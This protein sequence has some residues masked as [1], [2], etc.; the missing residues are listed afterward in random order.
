M[1][2]GTAHIGRRL[3][4]IRLWRGQS[5]KAVANLAGLSE[6]YL[7]KIE[8]GL[9]PVERRTTLE[10]LAAALRVAPSELTGSPLLVEGMN[11]DQS[12][13]VSLRA[14]L[15]EF[16]LDDDGDRAPAPWVQ[17]RAGVDRVNELRPKAEYTAMALMLPDLLRDLY[18]SLDGPHRREALQGLADCYLSSL[19]ACKNLGYSDLAIACALRIRD[20]S[21]QLAGPE[22]TGLAAYARAQA[23]G[24]GAR[25]RV[26]ALAVKAA[27]DITGDLDQ[28]QVAEVYGMLHLVAALAATTT[29]RLD[30]ARDHVAEAAEVAARPGVGSHGS[31]AGFMHM[32]FGPGNVG[33]WQTMLAVESGEGGRA[34]EIARGLDP[35]SIPAASSRQGM[36]WI[37]VGRGLAMER[38]TRDEAVRAF[39][40]AE[41]IAPQLTRANPWVR[42]TVTGLL[43]RAQ[44]DAGGRELRGLAYRVGIAG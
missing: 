12:A 2:E 29:G 23:I 40:R 8:R 36:W 43:S 34:V 22:W 17:V 7:S 26:G 39:R 10:A 33:L 18:A 32:W 20:V 25:D 1:A 15:G 3:R 19:S 4:E 24:S 16:D 37:D 14:A 5:L 42:E 38:G 30:T 41:D 28:P 35:E 6:G 44:R 13:V 11:V 31:D 27:D 21:H 9:K